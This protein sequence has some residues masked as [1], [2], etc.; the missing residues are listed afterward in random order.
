MA[1][2]FIL[3]AMIGV[4]SS[5]DSWAEIRDNIIEIPLIIVSSLLFGRGLIVF[6]VMLVLAVLFI[7]WEW[8]LWIAIVVTL[9]MWWNT[10]KTLQF[11]TFSD[12]IDRA[13][14]KYDA[15]KKKANEQREARRAL[16]EGKAEN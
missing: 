16:D 11:V 13:M 5:A 3:G 12:P 15:D 6:P 9:L 2:A 14:K 4:I 10:H 1:A 8:P 7:R